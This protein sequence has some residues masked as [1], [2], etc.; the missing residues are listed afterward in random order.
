LLCALL[1][2]APAGCCCE[3][4]GGCWPC[5]PNWCGPQCGQ[6]ICH[7]WCSFPPPCCDPCDDC[8]CYIGP[9]LNDS[10][11]S[12]GNDYGRYA[13]RQPEVVEGE[14]VPDAAP[15]SEPAP[16][17]AEPYVPGPSP[18]EDLPLDTTTGASYHESSSRYSDDPPPAPRF[19]SPGGRAGMM[20][21]GRHRP[22][23]DSRHASR[24]LAKP[25][26]TRSFS[27]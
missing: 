15:R 26:R 8:G 3:P 25:P 27:R 7:E 1:L 21:A 17:E 23:V 10:L 20:P 12:H 6:K 9:K 14:R 13:R 4:W 16:R 24:T 2:A 18:A 11:Y 22:M 5:G 19:R